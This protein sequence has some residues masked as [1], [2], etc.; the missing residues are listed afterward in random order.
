MSSNDNQ[1][2]EIVTPAPANEIISNLPTSAAI[3][4]DD[5]DF[6]IPKGWKKP[7]SVSDYIHPLFTDHVPDNIEDKPDY[8]GLQA[9]LYDKDPADLGEQFK[10][11][12]NNMLKKGPRGWDQAII[13]YTKAIDA[14]SPIEKNVAVYYSNRAHVHLLKSLF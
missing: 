6:V 9:I 8:L 12:G 7:D 1:E 2:N 13:S 10:D 5:D 4:D 11:E 14:N 3:D